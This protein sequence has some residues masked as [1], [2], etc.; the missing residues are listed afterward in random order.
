MFTL[1]CIVSNF[2]SDA[3]LTPPPH[4][5]SVFRLVHVL[6]S[7]KQNHA[8]DCVLA[9]KTKKKKKKQNKVNSC[10]KFEYGG[11]VSVLYIQIHRSDYSVCAGASFL[12]GVRR[13]LQI[14]IPCSFHAGP[15]FMK[16][17]RACGAWKCI[18][19]RVVI[20]F[21]RARPR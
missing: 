1:T 15:A 11:S 9:G 10:L 8:N 20:V 18:V 12:F 16:N 21:R 5:T 2:I 14:L 17:V 13:R 4:H 3:L 19:K 6:E 7:V